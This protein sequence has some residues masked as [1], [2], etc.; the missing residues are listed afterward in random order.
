M[1][2]P[3]KYK[4]L[5]EDMRIMHVL[6]EDNINVMEK[7]EEKEFDFLIHVGP[8]TARLPKSPSKNTPPSILIHRNQYRLGSYQQQEL[9]EELLKKGIIVMT[10]GPNK[11]SFAL[12]QEGT[13]YYLYSKLIDLKIL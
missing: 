13:F 10:S 2:I 4:G 11:I 8:Y 6:E 1:N 12:T 3:V 9:E 5:L 7:I